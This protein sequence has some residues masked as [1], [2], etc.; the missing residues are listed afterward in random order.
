M[1]Q[2]DE[3][4]AQG[5]FNTIIIDSS[6]SVASNLFE[7][8]KTTTFKELKDKTSGGLKIGL[9]IEEIPLDIGIDFSEDEFEQWKEAVDQGTVRSFTENEA[10]QIV[11][12][13]ASPEI[14]NA[15]LE[16]IRATNPIGTGIVC[17]LLSDEDA[18]TILYRVQFVPNSS[19]DADTIPKVEEFIV[20]GA[21]SVG[22]INKGDEIPFSGAVATITRNGRSEIT[23]NLDTEKGSCTRIIPAIPTPPSIVNFEGTYRSQEN[24]RYLF[25]QD[26]I[27]VTVTEIEPSGRVIASGA[28]QIEGRTVNLTY[29]SLIDKETGTA[30]ITLSADGQTLTGVYIRADTGETFALNWTRI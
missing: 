19:V 1:G 9:P 18:A 3:V 13:S 12:Q 26:G 15:W 2:C 25:E 6:R 22:G 5:V 8:L 21:T 20:T 4:L 27:N 11:R 29:Q 28:G 23:I 30:R 14:L 16:C 17:S 10:L 7:W 24:N